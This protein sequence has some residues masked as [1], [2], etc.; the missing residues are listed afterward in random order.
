MRHTGACEDPNI[1]FTLQ[2]N[3]YGLSARLLGMGGKELASWTAPNP[4]VVPT[5]VAREFPQVSFE[6]PTQ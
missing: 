3:S 5:D 4:F 1:V 6:L 2:N